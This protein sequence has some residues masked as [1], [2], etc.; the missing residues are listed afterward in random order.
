MLRILPASRLLL[1]TL[2]CACLLVFSLPGSAQEN[3]QCLQCHGTRELFIREEGRE[4]SLFVDAQQFNASVHKAFSCQVCHADFATFPHPARA[5]RADCGDCHSEQA[6]AVVQSV[7]GQRLGAAGQA[8]KCSDCH[9]IHNV[10]SASDPAASVYPL[11]IPQ[12]CGQ[13]HPYREISFDGV[14]SAQ[15]T[16]FD[17]DHHGHALLVK[18]LVHSATCVSCHGAHDIRPATDPQSR[19]AP[20]NLVKTCGSCHAGIFLQYQKS[21]HGVLVELG[22]TG[23][24]TCSDCHSSHLRR[25]TG[26]EM[27]LSIIQACSRCHPQQGR[28]Y[29]NTYHG[30]VTALGYTRV[31][32]CSS[33]HGAHNILPASDPQSTIHP[34]RI[35]KVCAQCHAGSNPNF[36]QY[37]VHADPYNRAAYPW[38][39][40]ARVGMVGL[41]VAVFF[42]WGIHTGLR[43]YRF[44][45]ER[46][47]REELLARSPQERYYERHGLFHRL[48]HGVVIVSFLLL[49]ATGLPLRYSTTSW[50]HFI[51]RLCGGFDNAGYLHRLGAILTFGYFFTHVGS[52]FY[53]WLVRKEKG[54]FW[55]PN[56]LVPQLKDF[57]DLIQNL[58][59]FLGTGERPK[60]DRWTYWEKFDYWAVFWGMAIIGT[61]G[62]VMWLSTLFTR[63]FPGWVINVAHVLHSEEALLAVGY[64]FTIHFFNAHL[65]PGKFPMDMV[66]FNGLISETELR[67]ERP[68]E[69]ARMQASGDLERK[70]VVPG[71]R[72]MVHP[73]RVVGYT[74]LG[75]GLLLVALVIVSGIYYLITAR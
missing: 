43:A 25:R 21:L 28:T 22:E 38:L 49:A 31:A 15:V 7:H 26:D 66:I 19:I 18:G 68:Q 32:R 62:L 46:H 61:S 48:L 24:A 1:T 12:T 16:S 65:R 30:K 9:T 35:A 36:A 41:L 10:R 23:V 4:R 70:A 50:G 71:K 63:F 60:F 2:A 39:Y 5:A 44:R 53:R 17:Q 55:G 14:I 57:T 11:T 37:L 47:H 58:R 45:R 67:V 54:L 8:A 64:I 29:H 6:Q 42:F 13:C 69:Y 3:G 75:I 51:M 59:W 56:S 73:P 33:C 40:W 34:G 72:L 74:A 27:V 52:V 20:A